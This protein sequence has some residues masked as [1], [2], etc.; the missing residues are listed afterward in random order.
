[1]SSFLKKFVFIKIEISRPKKQYAIEIFGNSIYRIFSAK[2]RRL[3]AH[4]SNIIGKGVG[5]SKKR[6]EQMAAMQALKLMGENI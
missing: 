4:F 1:M 2:G 5:K 6:A 3:A